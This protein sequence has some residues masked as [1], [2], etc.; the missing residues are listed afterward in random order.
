MVIRTAPHREALLWATA[1]TLLSGC[2]ESGAGSGADA[3]AG[4]DADLARGVA[5]ERYQEHDFGVVLADAQLLRH[6]FT[7]E[8]SS[9][10]PIQ[11]LR[12]AALRP[13][14]SAIGPLPQTIPPNG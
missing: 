14:C 13:C 3:R 12:A 2:T 7:L 5:A 8:N 1:V 11:V 10:K 4:G 6:E 9:G